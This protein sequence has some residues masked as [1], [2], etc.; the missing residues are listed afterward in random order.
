[1]GDKED[2]PPWQ[3]LGERKNP[4]PLHTQQ[5]T[6]NPGTTHPFMSDRGDQTKNNPYQDRLPRA[7]LHLTLGLSLLICPGVAAAAPQAD[8]AVT[9]PDSPVQTTPESL[10]AQADRAFS[11]GEQLFLEGT[12]EALSAAIAKLQ[13]ARTLYQQLGDQSLEAET[14]IGLA[15]VAKA[16]RDPQGA[17]DYLQ[18]ALTLT[19]AIEDLRGV[20]TVLFNLGRSYAELGNFTAA[21]DAYNQARDLYRELEIPSAEAFALTEQGTVYGALGEYQQA[22]DAYN[23]ALPLWKEADDRS[24][25]AVTLNN[26]G[27]IYDD[28]G[29][30]RE[31]L[32]YY[33]QAL[34]L[35]RELDDPFGVALTLN[36]IGN[37]YEALG[38]K[39]QALERYNEALTLW[40]VAGD[41][42]GEATTL[43]NIG[44]LYAKD[45]EYP[46]ALEIYRQ[47][48]PLWEIA[49]DR[50]G[51]AS[52]FNNIGF[53]YASLG[54]HT[55]A[56][57]YY[58]KALP[59]RQAVGDRPKEA[60][61]R[62][63][64]AI[65]LRQQ[66]QFDQAL[67]EIE[68]AIAIAEDLRTN[69]ASQ[70]ARASFF[71]KV[72]DYYEFYIDL[73]M[74]L[75]QQQPTAGF[76]A[77]ALQ[78]SEQGRARSLLEIL[79]EA[80]ADIRQG[81]D[82][83]LLD[84]E[85]SIQQQLSAL[86][87]RR[88]QL[89]SGPHTPEQADALS[90]EIAALLTQY[91]RVQTLLRV[92]SPRYAALT[93]PQP[94]TLTQIQ[95][96]VLD[97]DSI[98]L[99]YA[100]GEERSYLWVVTQTSLTSYTLPPRA[101]IEQA[102]KAFRDALTIPSLRIRR[103]LFTQSATALS[104]KILAPAAEFLGNDK[105][106]LVVSDGALQ[107]IPFNALAVPHPPGD[108]P[109][110]LPL[111]VKHEIVTLPSASTMAVLRQEV[112]GRTPA[113]RTLAVL[114]DPVFTPEDDRLQLQV[115]DESPTLGIKSESGT[116]AAEVE[117]SRLPY[118]KLE[119]EE[120][121]ALVPESERRK[122]FGFDASREAA[123]NPE[124]SQY[125]I[126]HFATH[127]LLN[128]V[129]PELS[130][131]V[132]SL[133]NEQG[134]PLNGFLRLHEIFNLDLPAEL[135]VLSACETGLGQEIR[136]EGLVGLTRGFMYAG[137]PRVLVSLWSVDD[138]AT[139]RLMV[140]FYQKMLQQG[141]TPA[142]ALR[143]AQIELWEQQQWQAPF[144][145]AGFTLQG[146]WQ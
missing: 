134:E 138:E 67:T 92:T 41:R 50:R 91:R 13:E 76:D 139:A 62:Y 85:R 141:L 6:L 77:K 118:T 98:L 143:S 28:L 11:A 82:P 55:Q 119:A 17:L 113:A 87:E 64:M 23:E 29:Q 33:N 5:F 30:Y 26:I 88:I 72:Q 68:T 27:K 133:L 2:S 63:R 137:A 83:E 31:A 32:D 122:A 80:N 51:K 49:G 86:E 81:A 46:Q 45:G 53:V 89:L 108:N 131:L 60:L 128:S 136:G 57:E 140:N 100:L 16:S 107:Y 112:A 93:Q 21:L 8:P 129:N 135:I 96:Q 38:D 74:E 121:L 144:F 142:A 9:L 106:L 73:L 4:A 52:T 70:D 105:R 37:V 97:E 47:G 117:F 101:E 20:A 1:M 66:G 78:A 94:L 18:Q 115:S 24:G 116:R 132:F 84:Q 56:L 123:T 48:L 12:P 145:W 34:P 90:Q 39:Q 146:E 130:G 71:A 14:L 36:N 42:R 22:L 104:E 103:S 15:F 75:H 43:N 58:N 40:Q 65:A 54:N 7:I 109:S 102:A 120:I 59:L 124:L 79:N 114:A 35:Y 111:M 69:V 25:V 10:E 3:S 125:R 99:E 126:V 61:T 95:Q 44:F 127:G 19:Q 110:Y